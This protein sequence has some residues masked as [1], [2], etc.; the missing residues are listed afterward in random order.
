MLDYRQALLDIAPAYFEYLASTHNKATALAKIVGFYTIKIHDLQTSTKKSMDLLVMENLFYTQDVS[1]TYDLKGI[2]E[3]RRAVVLAGASRLLVGELVPDGEL[4]RPQ[5]REGCRRT[6]TRMGR[7]TEA[8]RYGTASGS[9]RRQ[10]RQLC[11]IRVCLC[12]SFS[13]QAK[14]FWV[15]QLTLTNSLF[16]DAR[17]TL[18]DSLSLDTKFLN[19]QG[20]MDY[21]LLLGLDLERKVLVTG[22]VDAVGSFGLWKRLESASKVGLKGKGREGEVTVVRTTRV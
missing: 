7:T 21:S 8:A 3:F 20:I 17:R 16:T 19:S 18:L 14:L 11:F 6:R 10:S 1:K 12:R 5:S 4:I 9:T 15:P 22:L 13:S 2:G